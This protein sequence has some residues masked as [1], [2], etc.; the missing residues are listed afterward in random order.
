MIEIFRNRK[1][2]SGEVIVEATFIFPIMFIIL[3][4]LIYMGNAFYLRSQIDSV[5]TEQAIRGASYCADPLLQYIRENDSVP[6]LNS[7]AADADPYRYIFGGMDG[8]EDDIRDSVKKEIL[9]NIK[10]LFGNMD[11]KIVTPSDKIAKF[12]NYVLY[13]TFS[14]EVE[15]VIEFPIR[16]LGEDSP[17][18]LKISSRA[19]SPVNDTAE[20]I[21]NTDMVVDM[22][23][24][25]GIGQKISDMFGKIKEFMN[26]FAEK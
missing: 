8:I 12:N 13:S 17:I 5:V 25:T 22:F 14:V 23:Q 7:T 24:G 19:E 11:P 20:F 1:S 9:N 26:S 15:Y 6:G 2:E 16:L 3:F 21:R 18:A 10:S 4:I